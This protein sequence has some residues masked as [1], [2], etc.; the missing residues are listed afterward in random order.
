MVEGRP[1]K[2]LDYASPVKHRRHL[3]WGVVLGVVIVILAGGIWGA[4]RESFNFGKS[5][6]P[7]PGKHYFT[8]VMLESVQGRIEYY[9]KSTGNYPP[10]DNLAIVQAL[11]ELAA[12]EASPGYAVPAD[13]G[14]RKVLNKRGEMVDAWGRPLAVLVGEDGSVMLYSFGKNGLD[15][16][17]G[18]D[19]VCPAIGGHA[20]KQLS[21]T[22]RGG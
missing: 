1:A 20:P 6:G 13:V 12:A 2:T 22:T 5:R 19:D 9:A 16:K 18:G 14:G 8:R 11:S 4:F 7:G 15:D 17:G 10:A 21:G 3:K